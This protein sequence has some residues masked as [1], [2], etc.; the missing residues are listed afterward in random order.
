M[1][2]G[3]KF[4]D[5]RR[6]FPETISKNIMKYAT[7]KVME[8]SR[9]TFVRR[10]GKVQYAYCT[11]CRK[12][13]TSVG[14]KHNEIYQCPSCESLTEV[15]QSG[16]GRGKM[17]DEA[18]LL[19]Y[20]KSKVNPQAIIARGIYLV[21]D[22]TGDY[23]DVDT[24]GYVTA[25]YLFEPGNSQMYQRYYWGFKDG[26]EGHFFERNSICSEAV[27]SMQNKRCYFAKHSISKAVKGTPFQYSTWEQYG[28]EYGCS[29]YLKFFELAS[30]YRCIEF[31]TKI[32]LSMVV[33]EKLT[34]KKTYGAINWRGSTPEKVLRLSKQEIKQIR[35]SNLKIDCETI[36]YYQKNKHY[37]I[38]IDE[39]HILSSI[40]NSYSKQI[41][42]K[43][44]KET[45]LNMDIIFQYV[46]KQLRKEEVSRHYSDGQSL[47]IAWRDY[48]DECK[49]LGM[50]T[51]IEHILAPNNIYRAH[52]KTT[53]KV[54]MKRDKAM[55]IKIAN[56]LD[57]LNE[58]YFE[59]DGFIL[60]P[61][62]SATELFKEGEA[63]KHCV[64][65]YTRRY[66]S[67]ETDIFVIRKASSPDVPFY[68]MEIKNGEIIQTRGLRNCKMTREVQRF[69]DDFKNI[70]LSRKKNRVKVGIAV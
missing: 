67:G 49:E 28:G 44:I 68:T 46:I 29:D 10:V 42:D 5:F 24:K 8:W 43:L 30:K 36:S 16:R 37:S 52:Q 1:S 45:S 7:N 12:E 21:R 17:Y 34:G 54:R 56:R 13:H 55:N 69:V 15:K 57:E 51:K 63:L 47:L 23:H 35:L 40:E 27:S 22:Y 6:H 33:I 64:G 25:M 3:S 65:G 18:Y 32:G 4:K 9:Y 61:A 59:S 31:L 70:K 2:G 41:I 20:E 26:R 11:H 50:D 38:T 60:R 62:E 39:A 19:Y 58:Y 53:E 48:L 66:A 14:L